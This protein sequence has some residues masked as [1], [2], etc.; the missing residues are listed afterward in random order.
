MMR[1]RIKV[2]ALVTL[3]ATIAGV[4]STAIA[5]EEK[6]FQGTHYSLLKQPQKT[7]VP[8]G[9]VEIM[10]FFSYGCPYCYQFSAAMKA[11]ENDLPAN[12]QIVYV[13]ASF[14]PAESWPLFQRTYYTA[15]ALGVAEKMH[16]TMFNAVWGEKPELAIIDPTTRRLKST[17]P[18][19]EDVARFYE[20]HAGIKKSDFVAAANSPAVESKM[21][22][23][24][25]I[26][27]GYGILETPT[28]LVNGKY[29]VNLK[30]V[31]GVPDF[32]ELAH[33]LVKKESGG[34]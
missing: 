23:A 15:Q 32:V 16:E 5:A 13:P 7:T 11:L 26:I 21:K 20:A 18:T 14:I 28:I 25:A 4:W 27:N 33:W 12:A 17:P 30:E 31:H 22:Q 8:A 34:S 10:E 2:L 1:V 19:I 24:N 6:W 9:K 29:R 3:L